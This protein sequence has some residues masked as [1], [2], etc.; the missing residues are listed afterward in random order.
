LNNK[1]KSPDAFTID[2]KKGSSF[3]GQLPIILT[4]QKT[5]GNS[6]SLLNLNQKYR[7]GGKTRLKRRHLMQAEDFFRVIS[8]FEF[9]CDDIDE[10][11]E[12]IDLTKSEDLK[13]SQAIGSLEKARKI[14]TDLFPNIKSLTEDIREDL[15]EEFADIC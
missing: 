1:G 4:S 13:I 15:E 9:I 6:C 5:E 10:I 8:E 7:F 14:L 12:R 3:P 11:K 2:A